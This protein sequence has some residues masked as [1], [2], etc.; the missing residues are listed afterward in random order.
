MSDSDSSVLW[1]SE[2]GRARCR[3]VPDTEP[4]DDSFLECQGVEDVAEVK[5]NREELWRTIEREGV[6]GLVSEVVCPHC[7]T[8][9]E[10]DACWAFV[11]LE[12][13]PYLDD[14]KARAVEASTGSDIVCCQAVAS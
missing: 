1:T 11:G 3:A 14:F 4:F 9:T 6:W 12:F 13:A 10:V 8:W 5:A 7:G 2:D